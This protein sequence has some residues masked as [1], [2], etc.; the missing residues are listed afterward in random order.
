MVWCVHQFIPR[1]L[2]HSSGSITLRPPICYCSKIVFYPHSSAGVLLRT[3]ISSRIGILAPIASNTPTKIKATILLGQT[4]RRP[5]NGP[6]WFHH[7]HLPMCKQSRCS[8]KTVRKRARKATDRKL[9][10]EVGHWKK[11]NLDKKWIFLGDMNPILEQTSAALSFQILISSDTKSHLH[12]DNVIFFPSLQSG[13]LRPYRVYFQTDFQVQAFIG[14]RK[15]LVSPHQN[16][17]GLWD[18]KLTGL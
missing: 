7:T 16:Q 5:K 1:A 4:K 13:H 9:Q 17:T 6:S 18:N 14:L 12:Q 8:R 3:K 2:G 15:P 10:G 11:G